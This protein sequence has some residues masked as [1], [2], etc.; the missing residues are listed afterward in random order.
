MP[1]AE[2]H[3]PKSKFKGPKRMRAVRRLGITTMDAVELVRS[4]RR[5]FPYASLAKFQKATA[6]PWTEIS[7]FVAIPQRTLTRRQSQ[8]RLQPDES[9]RVLRASTVFE[10]AVEL[11]E[12]DTAG[13]RKWL[14]SPQPGLGG[15][16][17]LDFASTEVGAR[18]VENLIGRLEHGV[19]A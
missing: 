4:V 6:L 7:R 17:P 12:G 3:Q 2:T 9:D 10:R 13:A 18:E 15:E 8:G 5:G 14:Q 19:F 11:F 16:T 1:V